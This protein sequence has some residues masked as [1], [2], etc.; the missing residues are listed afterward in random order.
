MAK[1]IAAFD[2]VLMSFAAQHDD[3]LALLG[4]FFSFLHRKTDFYVVDERQERRMG[5]APGAAEQLVSHC[6]PS[7]LNR[8]CMSTNRLRQCCDYF[9][10]ETL[11]P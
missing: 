2:D 1:D 8:I 7:L 6:L 5:F 9:A 11:C 10:T 4:S 3:V